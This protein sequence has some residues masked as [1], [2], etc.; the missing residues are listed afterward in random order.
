MTP[1]AEKLARRIRTDGPITVADYMAACLGDPEYGYYLH[2]EPF[3]RSGDF[4]TAPEVSQM[5]GELIGVWSVLTWDAMGRPS[6]FVLA[7]LGPGRGSLMADL[8]RAA[9]VRPGFA[10]A[11]HVHLVET[12][13][14]LRAV[15][16]TSLA[17]LA[18]SNRPQWHAGVD[19]L[20]PAPTIV[21]ANEFF[22]ALPI[23][24]YVRDGRGW[25]ERMIGIDANMRL[26]YGLR[27][28]ASPPLSAVG[29]GPIGF[30]PLTEAASEPADDAVAHWTVEVS[31]AAAP[32]ADAIARRLVT[33]GGAALVI[34]YGYRGPAVADTLQAVRRHRYD[35]PLAAPGEADLTAHVDF[36]A[37]A[38]AATAAGATVR[39]LVAQGAFLAG[40]GLANR[41][42]RLAAGKDATTQAKIRA[43]AEQLSGAEAM[44]KLFKVL[45]F[46]QPDLA[47][48]LFDGDDSLVW[49]DSHSD[50]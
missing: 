8:L 38:E 26:I 39:P 49:Q 34:D 47:L 46:S 16:E 23:R 9:R 7:E 4:I 48:P 28:L 18:L 2:R 32:I 44:G 45:T 22:D 13:D 42:N 24:Q 3:G 31:P 27:P 36:T 29:S 50:A 40:L 11:A 10:E 20:P 35:D 25:A 37:L 21:I 30:D 33:D 41:A 15:Q 17:P 1:L 6:P 43:A 5:F 14:R 19:S 12:S